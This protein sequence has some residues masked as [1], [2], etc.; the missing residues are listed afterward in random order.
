MTNCSVCCLSASIFQGNLCSRFF[1]ENK[2]KVGGLSRPQ[3][4]HFFYFLITWNTL[5]PL[6]FTLSSLAATVLFI[7]CTFYCLLSLLFYHLIEKTRQN[8]YFVQSSLLYFLSAMENIFLFLMICVFPFC[9]VRFSYPWPYR[10]SKR[11]Q[12]LYNRSQIPHHSDFPLLVQASTVHS[13][14][15]LIYGAE[16]ALCSLHVCRYCFLPPKRHCKTTAQNNC[17]FA[18]SNIGDNAVA[19]VARSSAWL[20]IEHKFINSPAGPQA[21]SATLWL[22]ATFAG[23]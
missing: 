18:K 4:S 16:Q 5:A 2:M 8:V 1:L 13:N 15:L 21:L 7:Q 9:S 20:L 17:N 3:D 10:G 6:L 19:G 23:Y 11:W 12:E 22:G 14:D